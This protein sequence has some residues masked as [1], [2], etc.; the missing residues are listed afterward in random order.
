MINW[1][2]II[3]YILMLI[4]TGLDKDKAILKAAAKFGISVSNILKR[5]WKQK[6][7][8]CLEQIRF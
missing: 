6:L 4:A 5:F 7:E 1:P 8:I 3:A 2:K